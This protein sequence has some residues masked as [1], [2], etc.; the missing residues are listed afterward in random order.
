MMSIYRHILGR[1][2]KNRVPTV[3]RVGVQGGS[4]LLSV[5]GQQLKNRFIGL[6]ETAFVQIQTL[7]YADDG[8]LPGDVMIW[9]PNR[10]ELVHYVA[11]ADNTGK[12]LGDQL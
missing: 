1:Y 7:D 3:S 4:L 2:N 10:Q 9:E 12:H 6:R 5:A 11:A 8:I